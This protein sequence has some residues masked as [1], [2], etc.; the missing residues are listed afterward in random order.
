MILQSLPGNR[1]VCLPLPVPCA[2]SSRVKMSSQDASNPFSYH[3]YSEQSIGVSVWPGGI[4][5]QLKAAA[6]C[7]PI[8]AVHGR[9]ITP[10]TPL[11]PAPDTTWA[12]ELATQFTPFVLDMVSGCPC[13]LPAA[14]STAGPRPALAATQRPA[15]VSCIAFLHP[16]KQADKVDDRMKAVFLGENPKHQVRRPGQAGRQ[17]R[18][19]EGRWPAGD[20]RWPTSR[21]LC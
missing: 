17:E 15:M 12:E 20:H 21:L 16:C 13:L 3:A 19:G 4:P 9:A 2:D 7:G 6:A 8:A 10:N 18:A 5:L 14:G 1:L 11:C